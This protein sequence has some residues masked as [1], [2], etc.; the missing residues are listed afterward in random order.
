M[1]VYWVLLWPRPQ[2]LMVRFTAVNPPQHPRRLLL[3]T[4][5]Y[6]WPGRRTATRANDAAGPEKR[7]TIVTLEEACLAPHTQCG[8]LALFFSCLLSLWTRPRDDWVI[9]SSYPHG[10][11]H[12]PMLVKLTSHV[13]GADSEWLESHMVSFLMTSGKQGVKYRLVEMSWWTQGMSWLCSPWEVSREWSRQ[14]LL[15]MEF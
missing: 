13:S 5:P 8:S 15:R 2:Y 10:G 9:S 4:E 11:R 7:D 3:F 1:E 6:G 12:G 14:A